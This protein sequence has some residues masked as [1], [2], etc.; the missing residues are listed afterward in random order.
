VAVSL[1]LIPV[2]PFIVDRIMFMTA[3][4]LIFFIAGSR[5]WLGIHTRWVILFCGV[6]NIAV[7]WL[8]YRYNL[9]GVLTA[10]ALICMVAVAAAFYLNRKSHP[11]K[12]IKLL[13]PD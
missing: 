9:Q 12:K 3:P 11:N 2:Y 1:L 8:I 5:Y 10:G 7:T 13:I 6:C 4:G